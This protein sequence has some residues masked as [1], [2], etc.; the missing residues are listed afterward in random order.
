MDRQTGG[1]YGPTQLSFLL[2]IRIR[3]YV[4]FQNHAHNKQ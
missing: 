2:K 4:A 1:K 3:I